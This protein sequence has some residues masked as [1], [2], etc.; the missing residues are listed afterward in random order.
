MEWNLI[1]RSIENTSLHEQNASCEEV[2]PTVS[3][4][5]F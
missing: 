3:E 4:L 5:H 2:K 1:E